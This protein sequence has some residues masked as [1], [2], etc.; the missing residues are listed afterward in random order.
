MRH[1]KSYTETMNSDERKSRTVGVRL[2]NEY[3]EKLQA[4]A[5]KKNIGISTLARQ[6]VENWIDEY[7]KNNE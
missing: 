3:A 1:F 6:I 5:D 2:S 4:I 7:T